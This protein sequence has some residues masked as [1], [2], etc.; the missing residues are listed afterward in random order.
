MPVNQPEN[1]NR[2][3]ELRKKYQ[4]KTT[5]TQEQIV[6]PLNETIKTNNDGNLKESQS[7]GVNQMQPSQSAGRLAELKLRYQKNF[8]TSTKIENTSINSNFQ[9]AAT[10]PENI[11]KANSTSNKLEELKKKYQ[12]N[13]LTFSNRMSEPVG[14]IGK[15]ISTSHV[16]IT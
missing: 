8:E 7:L 4:K 2:L 9:G 12:K 5:E 13:E 11:S 3:D 16:V 6:K 1:S 14:K 10:K 15:S